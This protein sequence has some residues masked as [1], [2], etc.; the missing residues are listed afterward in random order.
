[1]ITNLDKFTNQSLAHL[2]LQ[3]GRVSS[4]LRAQAAEAQESLEIKFDTKL[5]DIKAWWLKDGRVIDRVES[6]TKATLIKHYDSESDREID[7]RVRID[8]SR[9][10]KRN[11][12]NNDYKN[13]LSFRKV[14]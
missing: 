14:R 9:K 3:V 1:M 13:P 12:H 2:D 6:K 11:I 10:A 7:E 8:M 5:D 4:D